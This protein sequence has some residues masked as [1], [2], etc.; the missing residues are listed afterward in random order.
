MRSAI[1]TGIDIWNTRLDYEELQDG[2]MEERH[3][4]GTERKERP[5]RPQIA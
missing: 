4:E 5:G 3:L 2:K 1:F